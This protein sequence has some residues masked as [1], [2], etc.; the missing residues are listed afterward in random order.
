MII[1]RSFDINRC[2]HKIEKLKGG[3]VGGSITQGLLNINDIVEMRPGFIINEKGKT[4][5]RPI[6]SRVSSLQSDTRQLKYAFPGGLIGVGLDID[7]SLTKYNGMVGQR[8]GQIGSL[9]PVYEALKL[10][11]KFIKRYD[12]FND[13]FKKNENIL[14]CV[15][16]MRINGCIKVLKKKKNEI[17]VQLEKPICL[18]NDNKIAIFKRISVDWKLVAVSNFLEGLECEIIYSEKDLYDKLLSERKNNLIEIDYDVEDYNLNELEYD[19][20]INNITFRNNENYKINVLPP[21]IKYKHPYTMFTNFTKVVKSIN[22][23]PDDGINYVS[24]LHEHFRNELSCNGDLN[25]MNQLCLRGRFRDKIIQN[26]L[27]KFIN[28]YI[29]CLSCQSPRC[30]LFKE[31]KKLYR[32]CLTCYSVSC[33]NI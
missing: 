6:I 7:P 3:V 14:I 16:S 22:L 15:N 29:K 4:K 27:I 18:S 1:I 10:K 30:Y 20:L 23:S 33:V 13:E 32:K 9:P 24:I 25:G 8:L 26:V 2:N 17:K 12:K 11:Y 28:K 5:C 31:N 19:K 21:E